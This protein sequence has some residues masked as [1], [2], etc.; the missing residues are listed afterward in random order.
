M[1]DNQRLSTGYFF[2][3]NFYRPEGQ[4]FPRDC[5][6]C[7]AFR[8][9]HRRSHIFCVW[10]LGLTRGL[11]TWNLQQERF[12]QILAAFLTSDRHISLGIFIH[13]V[14]WS[15]LFPSDLSFADFRHWPSFPGKTTFSFKHFATI[16][17]QFESEMYERRRGVALGDLQKKVYV[18]VLL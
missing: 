8:D 16:A 7:S 5:W 13:F 10:G 6:Y 18:W 12:S 14:K 4:V 2:R 15:D 3:N 11:T 9:G 17:E 1:R